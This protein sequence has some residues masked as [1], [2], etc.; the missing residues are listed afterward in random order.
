VQSP[1]VDCQRPTL[2]ELQGNGFGGGVSVVLVHGP[3]K[4]RHRNSREDDDQSE[5]DYELSQ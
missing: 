5:D 1:L 4:A 2:A 3:S